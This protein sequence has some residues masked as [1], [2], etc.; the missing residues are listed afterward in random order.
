MN[1]AGVVLQHQHFLL[2]QTTRPGHTFSSHDVGRDVA[3]AKRAAADGQMFI[4]DED[5]LTFVL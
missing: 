1:R 3:A 4:T 5:R 2:Q